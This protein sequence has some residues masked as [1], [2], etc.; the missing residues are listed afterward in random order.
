MSKTRVEREDELIFIYWKDIAASEQQRT[1][2]FREIAKTI[3]DACG[4]T[5]GECRLRDI[6]K[7]YGADSKNK[8]IATH[9]PENLEEDYTW[10]IDWC[11]SFAAEFRLSPKRVRF[12]VDKCVA[13]SRSTTPKKKLFPW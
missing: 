4:F 8:A 11:K 2:N 7:K 9:A 6:I 13:W 10:V 1:V 3:S 12:L 5:V